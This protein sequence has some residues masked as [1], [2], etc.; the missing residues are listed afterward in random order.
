MVR[1]DREL[2][3]SISAHFWRDYPLDALF[4]CVVP[5]DKNS[6]IIFR[7]AIMPAG[8]PA[9]LL[10]SSMI[11]I[12]MLAKLRVFYT[13]FRHTNNSPSFPRLGSGSEVLALVLALA[14]VSDQ[15]HLVGRSANPRLGFANEKNVSNF[16]FVV[17][18]IRLAE[19]YQPL[20]SGSDPIAA[21]IV[22]VIDKV[23]SL[24]GGLCLEQWRPCYCH[25]VVVIV[26]QDSERFLPP[27]PSQQD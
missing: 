20:T 16:K 21:L 18:L 9:C 10:C 11:S 15:R 22:I 27:A 3:R 19:R 8:W 2:S 14:L 1:L 4:I 6:I 13:L 7:L 26:F 23:G 12:G 5:L 17:R 24:K 25:N